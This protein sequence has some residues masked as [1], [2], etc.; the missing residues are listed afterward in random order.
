MLSVIVDARRSGEKLHLLL[1]QLT[2]G[3][4]EGLVREVRIVA[5]RSAALDEL[6]DATG[7]E[8][9]GSVQEAARA[10][11]SERLLVLPA[12]LRLAEDWVRRLADHLATGGA[13]GVVRGA[14]PGL[15]RRGPFGVLV[16]RDRAVGLEGADLNRLR[17]QLGLRAARLG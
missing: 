12:D 14:P 11:R 16:Q 9:A 6:C 3:A 8:P 1:A 4:V 7:A 10:S 13:E 17:R 2:A 15:F 5:P